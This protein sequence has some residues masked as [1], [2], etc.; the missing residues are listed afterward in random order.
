MKSRFK[1]KGSSLIEVTVAFFVMAIGLL[2]VL[3]LQNQGTRSNQ[4]AFYYS[5]SVLLAHDILE[6]IRANPNAIDDYLITFEEGVSSATSC[7]NSEEGCSESNMATWDKYLWLEE[8]DKLPGGDGAVEESGD[9]YIIT[10]R[11]R[12]SRGDQ[13]VPFITYELRVQL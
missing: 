12:D 6:R 10:T 11:F 9:F 8:L 13:D 7:D 1:Q 4:N 5:Q 3:A 2:G